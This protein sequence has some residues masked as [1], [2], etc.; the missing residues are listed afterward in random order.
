M[1]ITNELGQSKPLESDH[2]KDGP[3]GASG[4]GGEHESPHHQHSAW[5][6]NTKI[7]LLVL[8]WLLFTGILMNKSEKVLEFRQMAVEPNVTRSEWNINRFWVELDISRLFC[9]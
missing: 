7:T 1:T 5:F 9:S 2:N 8:V 3:G 4:G 6:T